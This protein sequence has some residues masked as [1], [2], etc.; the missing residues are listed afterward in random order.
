MKLTEALQ[1]LNTSSASALPESRVVLACSFTPLH[2]A[3]FVAAHLQLARAGRRMAVATPVFGDIVA[4]L[5]RQHIE[6]AEY[7]IVALEW[8]DLDPRLGFRHLGGWNESQ[9]GAIVEA[10]AS[11]LRRLYTAIEGAA[12]PDGPPIALSLPGLRLPPV[13]ITPEAQASEPALAVRARLA[14]FALRCSSLRNVRTIDPGLLDSVSPPS[15]RYDFRSDITS[16]FP[17]SIHHASVLA[18]QCASCLNPRPAMKGLITDLDDTVWKGLVGEVG[19]YGVRWDLDGRGQIHGVYQQ[20]L[21]SLAESGTLLGVAS[22]NSAD[23]VATVWDQRTDIILRRDS[24]FPWQVHWGPKSDSVAAILH[25]WNI[26]AESVVFV[27]D[28]AHEL[29]E[30]KSVFPGMECIP[31][32]KGAPDRALEFFYQLRQLF[33]KQSVLAEDRL[34]ARS[35]RSA[36]EFSDHSADSPSVQ[37]DFL[38]GLHG[39]VT[40]TINPP[41]EEERTLQLVNKTNQFNLNGLRRT[42]AEWN[43]RRHAKGGFVVSISYEDRLGPLGTISV[44][45]GTARG[46]RLTIDSWVLSC[47]A[48]SRLIEHQTLVFLFS[49]FEVETIEFAF[50]PTAK[51]DLTGKF[52]A[53]YTGNADS[54]GVV[55]ERQVFENACPR[56]DQQV[57]VLGTRNGA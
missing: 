25:Q 49:Q 36:V 16:G 35:I 15:D 39:V 52:L 19:A 56:L 6:S 20:M 41:A 18:A 46:A 2:L 54:G 30:V 42:Q 9:I 24:I 53:A 3:T 29:A 26:G 22:K 40:F 28:S 14:D 48:F 57:K 44:V 12:T 32:P 21:E 55:L 17:Y 33:G 51:N 7:A 45:Q 34:R 13:F 38:R 4:N 27:D 37:A 47:R 1:H 43:E 5:S 11:S 23:T 31:F 50:L 8:T 10:S